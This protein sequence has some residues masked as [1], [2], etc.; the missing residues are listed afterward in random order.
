MTSYHISYVIESSGFT[1]FL[2]FYDK[3]IDIHPL[4][5]RS[6]HPNSNL[7][8]WNE[9]P[10]EMEDQIADL[11]ETR[12]EISNKRIERLMEIDLREKP[13]KKSLFSLWSKG[14]KYD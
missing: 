13:K 4:I 9:I 10:E 3:I 7:I 14:D 2:S 5:W 11:E 12:N 6:K 8:A 1:N